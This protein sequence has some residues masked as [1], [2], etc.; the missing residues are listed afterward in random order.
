LQIT[1]LPATGLTTTPGHTAIFASCRDF[2][3]S[4]RPFFR[5]T[6]TSSS[7]GGHTDGP[8][9]T[10]LPR[11]YRRSNAHNFI[12]G[13]A[14]ILLPAWSPSHHAHMRA[15]A[16][17]HAPA[18]TPAPIFGPCSTPP[19]ALDPFIG[20]R[21]SA[22]LPRGRRSPGSSLTTGPRPS[23]DPVKTHTASSPPIRGEPRSSARSPPCALPSGD[24][25]GRRW[26]R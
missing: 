20:A 21:H 8:L 25:L 1:P 10:S 14:A 16:L 12:K 23:S 11:R 13:C 18:P 4:A 26:P 6:T 19:S 2:R 3:H 7:P 17:A 24:S 9:R 5:T 15:L 22:G